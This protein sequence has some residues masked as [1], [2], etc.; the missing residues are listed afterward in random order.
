LRFGLTEAANYFPEASLLIQEEERK[1]AFLDADTNPDFDFELY[2]ELAN[3][4]ITLLKADRD[5]FGD[6]L[7]KI[8]AAPGH[9][10]EN[11]VLFIKLAQYG[12]TVLSRDL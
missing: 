8:L 4:P 2:K 1:A 7:V 12:P 3:N 6:G 9:T 10:P 11:Q 5:I